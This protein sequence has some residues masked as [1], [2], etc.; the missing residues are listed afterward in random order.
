MPRDK[1]KPGLF[2]KF[3]EKMIS[4]EEVY[5]IATEN[6]VKKH[7]LDKGDY[8]RKF[9][10]LVDEIG[11]EAYRTY[12]REEEIVGSSILE[13]FLRSR[14]ATDVF[15]ELD[16][17]YLSLSQSRKV[18][19]GKAFEEIIKAL[20]RRCGYPFDEQRVINGKPDFLMPSEA[21]FRKHPPDCIILKY[22]MLILLFT[23]SRSS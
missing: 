15:R 10:L 7:K 6:A 22:D 14:H 2:E 8:P 9:S 12:L 16:R 5:K 18:R 23:F 4:N 3:S 13:D 19:A 1:T 21:H 11:E 20:F 17:F